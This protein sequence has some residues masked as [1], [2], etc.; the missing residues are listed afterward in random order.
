MGTVTVI[1][2]WIKQLAENE[3]QRDAVRA[4]QKETAD[5]R[6][7]LVHVHG[8]RLV[9][10]LRATIGRDVEAFR[11]E[12]AGDP[13]RAIVLE[14]QSEGRFVVRKPASPAV[15]LTVTMHPE[16]A[17]VGCHYHFTANGGLPPVEDRLELVFI[18]EDAQTMQ[19]KH[20]GTGR[21]FATA[22]SVSEFLLV[23][24]FTGRPR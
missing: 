8:R 11:E 4:R 15:S 24:V 19:I 5:R 16:A 20:Q 14:D 12:F 22:E 9:E 7:D 17:K 18:G 3:R 13:G 21:V 10:E 1:A 2:D 23:P 6:A